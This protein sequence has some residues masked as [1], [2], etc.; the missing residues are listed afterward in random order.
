MKSKYAGFVSAGIFA[1][2]AA[3]AIGY[4][5]QDT[6]PQRPRVQILASA[7]VPH[8]NL[9]DDSV[10]DET[11]RLRKGLAQLVALPAP[12]E[13]I[14]D[15]IALGQPPEPAADEFDPG[16]ENGGSPSTGYMLTLVFCS[17]E[18]NFCI[19]NG[20]FTTEGGQLPDGTSIVRIEPHRVLLRKG[21]ALDWI[22][23][24][25]DKLF[26]GKSTGKLHDSTHMEVQ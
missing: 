6:T 15:L 4:G 16:E 19:I 20:R 3:A 24:D 17:Q 7:A 25:S 8:N 21:G 1:L 9:P 14:V 18:K 13:D 2:A 5:F 23:P 12:E 26:T 10:L 22:Y 11:R